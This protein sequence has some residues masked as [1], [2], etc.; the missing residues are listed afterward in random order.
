MFYYSRIKKVES[1]GENVTLQLCNKTPKI[2][3]FTLAKERVQLASSRDILWPTHLRAARPRAPQRVLSP[4][5]RSICPKALLSSI[6]AL[7][8]H[9]CSLRTHCLD[10][11]QRMSVHILAPCGVHAISSTVRAES[12]K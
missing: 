10:A 7:L 11:H 6:N 8:L 1:K 9:A 4:M 5:L 3:F 12:Q 2:L